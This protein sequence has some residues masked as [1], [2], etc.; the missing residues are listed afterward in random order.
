MQKVKKVPVMIIALSL[1]TVIGLIIVSFSTAD[2]SL[3][4]QRVEQIQTA[5]NRI[6]TYRV[7]DRSQ[8]EVPSRLV[9][10]FHGFGGNGLR[11]G[12]YSALHNSLPNTIIV[13]PDAVKSK[14][15]GVSHGWNAGFCCGS[16]WVDQV[17]DV[18]FVSQLITELQAK[19]DINQVG[20]V[21]M[22]NGAMFAHRLA[23][24]LP[25][26]LSA[27]VS[28]AGSVGANGTVIS[29]TK[30]LPAL[31]IHGKLDTIV[32]Y[33]GGA[34]SSDSEFYWR[35]FQESE[36]VWREINQCE[37]RD[38]CE[39][40]TETVVYPETGHAWPGWRIWQLWRRQTSASDHIAQFLNSL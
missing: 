37:L 20:V 15:T 9:I 13:Y 34:G 16:G 6:R 19:Y 28:V 11:F 36:Q 14:Q 21:G 22:S 5:D 40:P 30:P 25:D 1:F 8:S 7:I 18:G 31:L 3:L 24:E 29:P 35:S 38:G 23:A 10:G 4:F 33:G 17:D 2:R 12:Y 26:R 27:V 39:V 32:P